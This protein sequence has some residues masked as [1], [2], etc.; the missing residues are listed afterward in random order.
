M[1]ASKVSLLLFSDLTIMRKTP[2]FSYEVGKCPDGGSGKAGNN[3]DVCKENIFI[4]PPAPEKSNSI[5]YNDL[6]DQRQESDYG[7]FFV[8]EETDVIPWFE[9]VETFINAIVAIVNQT[10]DKS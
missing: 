5:S 2:I 6:F 4:H 3:T 1:L 9:D 7:P 8:F 10:T